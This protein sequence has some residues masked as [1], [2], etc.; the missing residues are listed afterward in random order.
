MKPT[1]CYSVKNFTLYFPGIVGYHFQ[2]YNRRS[3]RGVP[4]EVLCLIHISAQYSTLLDCLD[5][6]SL[7][8]AWCFLAM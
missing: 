3:L 2:F 5:I 7:K 8:S 1:D 4:T 6:S